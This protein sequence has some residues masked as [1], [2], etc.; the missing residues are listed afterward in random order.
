MTQTD[1]QTLR[2]FYENVQAHYDLSNEFFSLMLDPSM[3]YTCAYFKDPDMTLEEAQDAKLDLILG[4]CELEP[5]QRLLDV[6]CGWGAATI[7]AVE[8]FGVTGVGI[9]LSGEQV[10]W[11]REKS[12]HLGDKAEFRLQGWED[13]HEPVDRIVAI[14]SVEHFK[15]AR[16]AAF[17]ARCF[18]LLPP[19]APLVIQAIMY[20]E[21]EVQKEKMLC[22]TH[23]DVLFAKFIA[24]KI[25]PGGQLRPPSVLKRYATEAG[26][27]V[28]S[29]ESLAPHYATTL[30]H[31]AVK[32][33]AN[34]ERAIEVTS[35]EVYDMYMH[36]VTG[37]ARYYSTGNL[38]VVQIAFRK[39]A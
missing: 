6:G 11:A 15:E 23:E 16:Y 39:P 30:N 33:E 21:Y 20:P 8:N 9:T 37:C 29:Q 27:T 1:T 13:F 34:K 31:W 5:G 2:P 14:C 25:F 10:E 36:Y 24:R 38:E 28:T 4:K 35:Q 3:L 19:G 18:E 32:L 12:A 17:F 26:F 7:Y 22:W